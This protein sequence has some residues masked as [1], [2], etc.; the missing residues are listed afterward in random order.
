MSNQEGDVQS[1]SSF[2]S[3]SVRDNDSLSSQ[4]KTLELDLSAP[5]IMQ[6]SSI[7]SVTAG[8]LKTVAG[9]I[10]ACFKP[11]AAITKN[12]DVAAYPQVWC[13]VDLDRYH[14]DVV[15]VLEVR[16][17]NAV[18]PDG[19]SY[20]VTL[21]FGIEDGQL[22]VYYH[23]PGKER[24][25]VTTGTTEGLPGKTAW[26]EAIVEAKKSVEGVNVAELFIGTTLSVAEGRL[27]ET[28]L[29]RGIHA[30]RERVCRVL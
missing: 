20:F 3:F 24:V 27:L 15:A 23:L 17:R 16:H 2:E 10:F 9:S 28:K 29:L 12:R 22:A 14:D 13:G 7:S 21:Y 25:I 8:M 19:F 5:K 11:S 30:R 4:A 6:P 18:A 26:N 1:R